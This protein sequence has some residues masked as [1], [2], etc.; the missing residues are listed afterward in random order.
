MLRPDRQKQIS[1]SHPSYSD[2]PIYCVCNNQ[3]IFICKRWRKKEKSLKYRYL[4]EPKTR[5]LI[6][7]A[8]K[9]NCNS[10]FV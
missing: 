1:I 10:K 4:S 2:D 5:Y 7:A 3:L 8:L 6:E 9:Q